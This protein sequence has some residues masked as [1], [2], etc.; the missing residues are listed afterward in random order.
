MRYLKKY[1]TYESFNSIK[2]DINDIFLEF[3]DSNNEYIVLVT[4]DE[5]N[6]SIKIFTQKSISLHSRN[7]FTINRLL[8]DTLL[9]INEYMGELGFK[10]DYETNYSKFIINH[11]DKIRYKHN[12]Q[13][14]FNEKVSFLKLIFRK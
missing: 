11:K 12:A 8:Y 13:D 3:E 7:W 6:Y 5:G 2:E 10:S 1:K 14:I 4:E 9:R